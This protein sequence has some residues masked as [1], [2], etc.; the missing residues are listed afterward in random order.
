MKPVTLYGMMVS[1]NTARA[2]SYL[3]KAGIPFQDCGPNTEH[4]FNNVVPLAGGIRT[5]PTMEFA[6]GGVIRDGAA[7]IEHFERE[8]GYAFSPPT[9]KQRFFSRLFDVIGAEGFMRPGMHYRWN[10]EEEN[11]DFLLF[12]TM[13]LM[14]PNEFG[15]ELAVKS[16]G[17]MRKATKS[18]GVYP[19]TYSIIEQLYD[20][21]LAALDAHFKLHPYLLGG[22][23][24][25]GDFGLMIMLFPHLG[26]DPKPLSIMHKKGLN[27]LRW[28]ERMNRLGGDFDGFERKDESYLENDE[29]PTTLSDLMSV[30]A[31]DFVP[32]TLAA[33]D[34]INSWLSEQGH[35][36][37]GTPYPRSV[38]FTEF[39]VRDT[40]ISAIA[41][42]YRFYL[43]QRVHDEYAAMNKET[44]QEVEAILDLCNMRA[45][46]DAKLSR[47]IGRKDNQEVWI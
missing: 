10:F 18:L 5:M 1:G 11:G 22:R 44:K 17:R 25:I 30:M 14:P 40:P 32:E 28:T 7:I 2:R 34:T 46:L 6:D 8:S 31:Q 20:E 27:V 42:P 39:Q 29:I 41:Q 19:E 9:P 4:Y 47:E 24:C 33:A 16:Q 3:I 23:P 37:A 12:Q 26:R 21:Q 13:Q 38:G 15:A 35:I 43:L 45:L 36:E